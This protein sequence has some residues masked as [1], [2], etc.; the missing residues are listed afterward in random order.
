MRA[1]NH[2]DWNMIKGRSGDHKVEA[3]S[4][5]NFSANLGALIELKGF[6]PI[7]GRKIGGAEISHK[8]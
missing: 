6:V 4:G 7:V 1:E 2:R 5:E 3:E 8:S